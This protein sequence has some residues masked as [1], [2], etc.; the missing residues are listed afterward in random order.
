MK[1]TQQASVYR[2]CCAGPL[3]SPDVP[4]PLAVHKHKYAERAQPLFADT[5]SLCYQVHTEDFYHDIQLDLFVWYCRLPIIPHSP[6]HSE[7]E[8]HW[9]V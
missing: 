4:I 1:I 7:Q 9:Q 6:Q 8:S 2:F 3:Q 5:D